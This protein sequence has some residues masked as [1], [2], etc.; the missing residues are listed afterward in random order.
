V[1]VYLDASALV[2][3][4][5]VE[6]GSETVVALTGGADIVAGTA[7]ISRAEVS[8]ALGTAVRMGMLSEDDGQEALATFRREWP[9][10]V[11]LR[12]TE[13]VVARADRLAWA[14]ALRGHDAVHLAAALLWQEALDAPVVL[15]TFDR[16]L[17]SAGQQAGLTVWP[18]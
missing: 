12:I 8:A 5:V 14:H 9:D 13:A 1:I 18:E 6:D 17:W 7:A 3:R 16:D 10:L 11:R 15:A 4:Y 2:K